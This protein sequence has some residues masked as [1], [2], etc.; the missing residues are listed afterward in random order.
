MN[1]ISTLFSEP[2]DKFIARLRSATKRRAKRTLIL[3]AVKNIRQ[4]VR[5]KK[6]EIV[7]YKE[8]EKRLAEQYENLAYENVDPKLARIILGESSGE[9]RG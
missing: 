3:R 2:Y 7:L 8:L 4:L 6:M 1:Q 9:A 5:I